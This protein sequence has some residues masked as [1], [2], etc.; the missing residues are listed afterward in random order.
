MTELRLIAERL[1]SQ[2]VARMDCSIPGE[3]TLDEWRRQR[4]PSSSTG[5]DGCDH[6]HDST[7]RYD[8]ETKQLTFLLVCPV[9]RTERV[10]DSIPYEPQFTPHE[11]PQ[12][13]GATIHQLPVRRSARPLR[14]AA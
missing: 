1:E 14:R 10:V 9:C 11:P 2:S 6:L 12:P 5:S 13:G 7:S 3:L 8:H 4:R